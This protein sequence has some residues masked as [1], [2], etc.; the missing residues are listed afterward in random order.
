[1][2]GNVKEQQILRI[3]RTIEYRRGGTIMVKNNKFGDFITVW[4]MQNLQWHRVYSG[5]RRA[6]VNGVYI[7]KESM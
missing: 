4:A 2:L 5:E 6:C 3:L 7:F 1:M